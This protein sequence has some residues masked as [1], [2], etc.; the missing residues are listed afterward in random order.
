M[1]KMD[2]GVST[3]FRLPAHISAMSFLLGLKVQTAK[4]GSTFSNFYALETPIIFSM[5][6]HLIICMGNV[7]QSLRSIF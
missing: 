4:A 3:A 1:E 5:K 6:M 7:S 2:T